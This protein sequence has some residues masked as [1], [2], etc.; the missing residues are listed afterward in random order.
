MP[1]MANIIQAASCSRADVQ[2]AINI[3]QDGDTVLVPSGEC[4]WNS[5]V[6][7]YD[8]T[9]TLIG[10]GSGIG[11]TKIIY[12]RSNHS[13]LEIDPGTKIGKVEITGFWF[14]GGHSD[15]WSGTAISFGGPKGW[16]NLLIHNKFG[17]CL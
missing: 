16:K 6:T 14:Y 12:G 11:G 3:S 10:N 17:L 4:I 13:L 5:E 1:A 8:K 2:A 7:I 15:Y 9:I